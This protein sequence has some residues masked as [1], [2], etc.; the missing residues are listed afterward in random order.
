MGDIM[1]D[2]K[3]AC[4]AHAIG[5]AVENMW[6]APVR[7]IGVD[8]VTLGDEYLRDGA[9]TCYCDVSNEDMT[10]AAKWIILGGEALNGN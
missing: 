4:R 10:W 1:T 9:A 8:V 2:H 5:C 3:F 6:T 7:Y